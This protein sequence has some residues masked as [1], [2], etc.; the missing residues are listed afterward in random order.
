MSSQIAF[1]I[2]TEDDMIR[3]EGTVEEIRAQPLPIEEFRL[4]FT[5]NKDMELQSI[6]ESQWTYYRKVLIVDRRL[7]MSEIKCLLVE[8]W[9]DEF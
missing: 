8:W 9:V 7:P 6:T 2:L 1:L 4:S 5:L 3:G